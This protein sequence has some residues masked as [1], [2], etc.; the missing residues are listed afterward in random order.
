M[1]V[2]EGGGTCEKS[3]WK[4]SRKMK[5]SGALPWKSQ[6]TGRCRWEVGRDGPNV[7]KLGGAERGLGRCQ[8]RS[9][10]EADADSFSYHRARNGG[11]AGPR[12]LFFLI[13]ALLRFPQCI[14]G[15]LRPQVSKR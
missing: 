11:W 12:H 10:E 3:V 15:L 2:T 5:V 4:N 9:Q 14:T 7:F 13:E 1:N 8:T 6:G